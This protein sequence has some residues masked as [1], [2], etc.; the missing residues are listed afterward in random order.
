MN[1]AVNQL[2][3]TYSIF[4]SYARE[5]R[6]FAER[7]ARAFSDRAPARVFTHDML[8]P[9]EAWRERLR[10]ALRDCDLFVM[11]GSPQAT[12]SDFVLQELGAAWALE[13][14]IV[15]VSAEEGRTWQLPI[16]STKT[17]QVSFLEL[18]RPGFV[19]DLLARVADRPTPLKED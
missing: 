11:I 17:Q 4:L 2:S 19:E 9:A 13:K 8:S 12:R 1:A 7:V 6:P 16:S 14:P 10:Q 18:E 3:R 5:D 15:V